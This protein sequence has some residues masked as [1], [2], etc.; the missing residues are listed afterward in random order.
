ML[1]KSIV[2]VGILAIGSVA[3]A[4]APP[5]KLLDP[6]LASATRSAGPAELSTPTL[7]Q[8]GVLS[9]G[10]L[11]LGDNVLVRNDGLVARFSLEVG[12]DRAKST[13]NGLKGN[14]ALI[15]TTMLIKM[16]GMHRAMD[17]G[18]PL[19]GNKKANPALLNTTMLIKMGGMHR[20][21]D[22]GSAL[23]GKKKANL[24]LINL[25]MLIKMGSMAKPAEDGK[26]AFARTTKGN[27]S[28]LNLTML[29]RTAG[30]G[31]LIGGA[32]RPTDQ[33]DRGVNTTQ[34]VS[35]VSSQTAPQTALDRAQ[36]VGQRRAMPRGLALD[37]GRAFARERAGN[38]RCNR[39]DC[40]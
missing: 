13:N 33:D 11:L 25:P 18:S 31:R 5:Q 26:G 40:N 12:I 17:S 21:M 3:Q 38:F 22:S 36:Q 2:I 29:I 10:T 35:R 28:Q 27:R 39:G 37:H 23:Q 6:V 20:A 4:K 30:S 34:R 15:N 1:R 32:G 19:Q 24:A 14:P 9:I 7:G 16:G 8:S